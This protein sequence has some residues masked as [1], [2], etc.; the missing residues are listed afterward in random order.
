MKVLLKLVCLLFIFILFY[1]CREKVEK[2]KPFEDKYAMFVPKNMESNDS[3]MFYNNRGDSLAFT[4]S[5]EKMHH[6]DTVHN[7]GECSPLFVAVYENR[8]YKILHTLGHYGGYSTIW[9]MISCNRYNSE[10]F[11]YNPKNTPIT[12]SKTMED[13]LVNGVYYKDVVI[14]DVNTFKIY[15]A[16][17]H[18]VIMF[19]DF[20]EVWAINKFE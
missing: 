16:K 17:D 2:C 7:Q 18:G 8:K 14:L 11:T 9:V 13:V 19:T 12:T 3:I 6:G 1:G 10:R 4:Y 20:N 5:T 15:V